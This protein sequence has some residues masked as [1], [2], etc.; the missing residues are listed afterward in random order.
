MVHVSGQVKILRR[1]EAPKEGGVCMM[2][3]CLQG[4]MYI[5]SGWHTPEGLSNFG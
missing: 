2:T 4:E 1:K 5:Y 3:E